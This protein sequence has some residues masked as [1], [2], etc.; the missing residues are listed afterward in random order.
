MSYKERTTG[1]PEGFEHQEW[2]WCKECQFT[3]GTHQCLNFRIHYK[4]DAGIN[5]QGEYGCG[6][7]IKL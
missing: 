7:K 1:I 3:R 5:R 2:C 4:F 6:K